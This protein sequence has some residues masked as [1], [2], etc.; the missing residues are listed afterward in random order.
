MIKGKDIL[1]ISTSD[2]DKP[3]GSKQQLMSRLS[4]SNRVL[5]VEYQA[6]FAHLFFPFFLRRTIKRSKNPIRKINNKLFIY[7]PYPG[8]PFGYYSRTI[9]RINQYMLLWSLKRILNKLNFTDIVLWI[10]PPSGVELLGKLGEK[11]ILYHCIADFPNEKK[12]FLRNRTISSMEK[13]LLHKANI[14]LVLTES[15]YSKYKDIN[16]NIHFFP[17]AVDESL[18]F[19]ILN[20]NTE[21]PQDIK[22][23]KRPRIGMVGCLDHR[24][25]ID[26]L[27]D[28][29]DAYPE[30]SLVIIGPQLAYLYRMRALIKRKNVYFLCQKQNK[31]I[32][33]YI[34]SFDVCIIPYVVNEFTRNVSPLKLYE[35][36]AMG[37]PVVATALP[38]VEKFKDVIMVA[39]NKDEFIECISASLSRHD[40]DAINKRIACAQKN[41]WKERLIAVSNLVEGLTSEAY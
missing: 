19:S 28:I 5:F 22:K 37:K 27:C 7:T 16:P 36:L 32:P 9:N 40:Q 35:Y 11:T 3:W 39:H 4:A 29:A 12:S 13:E 31:E 23:L 15:L 21:E 8:L 38:D 25:D 26:L 17:S 14:V 33:F 1:C 34:K 24:L 2:W 18:F 6:S 10:Y 41:T 30:S 20:K